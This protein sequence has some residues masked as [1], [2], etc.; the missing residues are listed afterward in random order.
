M[1]VDVNVIML[2]EKKKK[3]KAVVTKSKEITKESLAQEGNP[4]EVVEASNILSEIGGKN[5]EILGEVMAK[6]Y[7]TLCRRNKVTI[8]IRR[9][10]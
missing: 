10:A 4:G 3:S 5:V 9:Y 8:E 7:S 1:I 2:L 6:P